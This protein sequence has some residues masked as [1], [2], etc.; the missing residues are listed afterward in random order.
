[1]DVFGLIGVVIAAAAL[2]A[3][4]IVVPPARRS[5]RP[6]R[7][8]ENLAKFSRRNQELSKRQVDLA[9]QMLRAAPAE[10]RCSEVPLLQLEGWIFPQPEALSAV[11]LV[12][13]PGAD[14]AAQLM[15]Q[16]LLIKNVHAA[17][18]LSYSQAIA[19]AS[20]NF[21]YTNGVIFRP[22][23]IRQSPEGLSID[24]RSG[25]YFDYLDT[26]EVLSYEASIEAGDLGYRTR[27]RNP[28][29]LE[30]RVA[31]LGILTLTVRQGTPHSSFLMHKRTKNVILGSE[32]FHVV[33]AGEFA[34]SDVSLA[35]FRTDFDLWRNIVREYAEELLGHDD[36]QGG[37]GR[38]LD[39]ETESPFREL[40][41]ATSRRKLKLHTFG[42][43][44]DPLTWKPEL[45]T[46]AVFDGATFDSIFPWP[47]AGNKE[48]VVIEDIP[49]TEDCVQA[50]LADPATR[51]GAKAC[52]QLAWR[53][54]TALD[55][56]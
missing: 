30:N 29:D 39:Y 10:W 37:G 43:G 28:F 40:R 34:P 46:I 14:N 8:A 38:R 19:E 45:L 35:A 1:M 2:V 15:T 51:F 41:E 9:A 26:S 11:R 21:E 32:L 49:F 53:N 42:I 18:P 13:D 5:G 24:F 22:T 3:A 55:I 25:H 50:Y 20:T 54:R 44:L 17:G 52:L 6:A 48:G 12:Y 33:P 23:S 27:I 4:V 36:A 47:I 16:A 56:E 31:S 7:I